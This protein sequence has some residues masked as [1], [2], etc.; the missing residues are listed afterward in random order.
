MND[1]FNG[2][3]DQLPVLME[4]LESDGPRTWDSLGPLPQKGIYLFSEDGRDLYIGRSDSIRQRIRQHGRRGSSHLQA[5]FAFNLARRDAGTAGVDVNGISRE[6]LQNDAAF[7]ALFKESKVRVRRMHIRAVEV[8]D[9]ILQTLFEVYAS[10]E[11]N[12]PFN[13]FRTH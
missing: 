2:L 4:R 12:T 10:L 13:D 3:V 8:N 6:D 1:M 11:L 5:P 9:P 7:A